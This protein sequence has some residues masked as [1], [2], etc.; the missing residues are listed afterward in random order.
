LRD[1]SEEPARHQEFYARHHDQLVAFGISA[2]H[3]G[4]LVVA[5][6]K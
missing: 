3:V 4:A 1:R 6:G 5:F 2:E